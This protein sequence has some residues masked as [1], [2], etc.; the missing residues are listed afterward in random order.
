[1][2]RFT[3]FSGVNVYVTPYSSVTDGGELVTE[4]NQRAALNVLGWKHVDLSNG[5]PGIYEYA[6]YAST[7]TPPPTGF[8]SYLT[9]TQDQADFQLSVP[10][11]NLRIAPGVALVKGYYVQLRQELL[12]PASE[13]ISAADMQDPANAQEIADRGGLTRYVKLRLITT[14][15]HGNP[16]DE[17]LVPPYNG[18]YNGVVI[19]TDRD[20]PGFTELLLGTIFRDVNGAYSV[21]NNTLKTRV[22]GIEHI[23]GAENYGNLV[24]SPS[25]DFDTSI[26]GVQ[27]YRYEDGQLVPN[28]HNLISINPWTWLGYTSVLGKYLRNMARVPDDA[29]RPGGIDGDPNLNMLGSIIGRVASEP[30]ATQVTANNKLI[31]MVMQPPGGIP[32]LAYRTLL[33]GNPAPDCYGREL[34]PL[35]L[36]TYTNHRIADDVPTLSGGAHGIISPKTLWQVDQLWADRDLMAGGRQFGPFETKQEA[37]AF[38][39]TYS[40]TLE[41]YDYYWVLSDTIKNYA[42]P[43]D[44]TVNYGTI[45]T[46]FNCEMAGTV[47]IQA[48]SDLSGTLVLTNVDGTAHGTATP[49]DDNYDP[50]DVDIEFADGTINSSL[51]GSDIT[52]G[53]GTTVRYDPIVG[54]VTGTG[55]A[56]ATATLDNF[57]QNVSARYVWMEDFRDPQRTKK[58]IKQCV[59]RGFASPATPE[60]LGF[61]KP[62]DG[63]SIGDVVVDPQSG[64]LKLD[65]TGTTMLKNGGWVD[66]DTLMLRVDP[67]YDLSPLEGKRFAEENNSSLYIYLVGSGWDVATAPVLR[68]IRGKVVLNLT[69]ASMAEGATAAMLCEDV[70]HIEIIPKSKVKI[71]TNNCVVSVANSDAIYRWV[72]TRFMSGSNTAVVNN[73]WM[74]VNHAFSNTYENSL[75]VRFATITRGEYNIESAEMDIW[76]KREDWTEPKSIDNFSMVSINKLK[77]PPLYLELSDSGQPKPDP[78]FI[79]DTL[80]AKVSGTGGTHRT[81]DDATSQYVLTGNWISTIDWENGEEFSI[82]GRMLSPSED[83]IH[84]LKDIRFRVLVQFTEANDM[85]PQQVDYSVIYPST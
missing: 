4:F 75:Q 51:G 55:V 60:H 18:V 43:N 34:V 78:I 6:M 32:M 21:I 64:Q 59:L 76:I 38:F 71:N 80:N 62:S 52:V 25:G 9:G 48:A 84:G 13:I 69:Q 66:S 40:G 79:P 27:K 57:V 31:Q 29:G 61:V 33:S 23:A 30:N 42:D 1:M 11:S 72:N 74:T 37:D 16:H 2:A 15:A 53:V 5:D 81:W 24:E 14:Q 56:T 12:I 82:N 46:T 39:A 83:R 3:Y 65:P 7:Q 77:F 73:P 54:T 70:D 20:L 58:W 35:P 44:L 41:D 10:G 50:F 26:Y 63:N 17:R 49:S 67:D 85:A 8:Y 19:L 28:D 68:H 47:N 36:A 22:L 45:S